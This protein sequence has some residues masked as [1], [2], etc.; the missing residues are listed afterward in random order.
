MATE[1]NARGV[2]LHQPAMID[3]VLRLL[4]PQAGERI[5]DLTVGTGGHALALS[6]R[7]GRK[8][9]LLGIDRDERALTVAGRRLV[10]NAACRFRLFCCAFSQVREAMQQA[11]MEGFDVVFADLGVGTHQLDDPRRG[12]GFDST[13]KLDMRYDVSQELTAWQIVNEMPQNELADLFYR[14]GEERRSR[15]IAARICRERRRAP[16][17][18]PHRLSKLVK[19]VMARYGRGRT[20]RIHPATRVMMALRIFVNDELGQLEGL[21]EVL[22]EL[23]VRN[24]RAGLLTYHSL[25]ARRVKEAWRRQQRQGLLEVSRGKPIRPSQEE[26][27]HNPRVRSAQLR[28]ARRT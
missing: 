21:L 2:P 22:P 5:L 9:F 15:Q 24:G 18:T 11:G 27:K 25:E 7:V 12:F 10:E 3:E 20:W 17:D 4:D 16:I 1:G 8:G 13:E 6:Q 28:V 19:S 23:L 14:F 26:I